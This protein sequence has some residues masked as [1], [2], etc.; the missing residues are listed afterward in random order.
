MP[1][2]YLPAAEPTPAINPT[3]NPSEADPT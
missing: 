3:V 2:A 1:P